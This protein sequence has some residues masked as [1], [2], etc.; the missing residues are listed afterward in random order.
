[1]HACLVAQSCPTLCNP[2]DCSPPGSSVHGIFQEGI[3]EWVPISFSRG[4]SW[5]RDQTCI[6]C[7]GRQ[8]LYHWTTRKAHRGRDWV[9]TL[10][11]GN[12]T[13]SLGVGLGSY[14]WIILKS[15][16]LDFWP[17]PFYMTSLN[18]VR[19]GVGSFCLFY[20]YYLRSSA[21]VEGL[22][23]IYSFLS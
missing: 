18:V 22:I 19:F 20:Y 12:L 3:L 16:L 21:G 11:N 14:C 17:M 23:T 15:P 8:I 4:S 1:M 7:I 6:S 13:G 2:M 5:L 9:K 10:I